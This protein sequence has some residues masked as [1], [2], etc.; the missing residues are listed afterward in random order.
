M[1]IKSFEK[2]EGNIFN[3]EKLLSLVDEDVLLYNCNAKTVL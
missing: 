2:K 1:P 3:L